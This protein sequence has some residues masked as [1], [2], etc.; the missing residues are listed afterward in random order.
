[1]K[2][3]FV[4]ALAAAMPVVGSAQ[5]AG[6]VIS[7]VITI[8]TAD[9]SVEIV[10]TSGAAID[11]S[12]VILTDEETG[13]GEGAVSFPAS[14][15]IS[16]GEVIVVAVTA[17][18][19][20]PAWLDSLPAGVRVFVE[21][22]RVASIGAWTAANGNTLMA[23]NDVAGPT[24]NIGLSATDGVALF[25]PTLTF[26]GAGIS[27]PTLCIDGVNW[28]PAG[29]YLP[30]D[31]AGTLDTAATEIPYEHGSTNSW[32]RL[33]SSA[34]T[35]S[36]R[37]FYD[38][39]ET[40]GSHT[41]HGDT[42]DGA[43]WFERTIGEGLTSKSYQFNSLFG[44]SQVV[45]VFDADLD[46]AGVDLKFPFL[47]STLRNVPAHAATISG[48]RACINGNFFNLAGGGGAVQ[49]VKVDGALVNDTVGASADEGG[50]VV[51][52]DGD[53]R[54]EVRPG[55]GWNAT[56]TSD[57]NVP[58]VMASNI[59]VAMNGGAYNFPTTNFYVV[60]RHPRTIVGKTADN[61]LLL[62]S[63]DGRS[64]IAAGM[65]MVELTALM[66]SLGCESAINMDGGG[67]TTA[68]D[69]HAPGN[70]VTNVPS[71][72]SL[73]GV[74]NGLAIVAPAPASTPALDAA[75]AQVGVNASPHAPISVTIA[76]GATQNVTISFVNKGTTTWTSSTVFLGTTEARDRTSQLH[77][78]GD[79]VS[80]TRA[81]PLD[82]ASVAP[83]GTGSFT[84]QI[85]APTTSSVL[86]LV[87]SFGLVTSGNVFFGP[88]QNRL[89]VTVVP[90]SLAGEV[91]VESRQSDVAGTLTPSPT[92]VESGSFSNTTSKSS[93]PVPDA[94]G[95]GAR[96]STTVGNSAT[97]RPDI[98][99]AGTYDVFVTIGTGSNNN[100][101]ASFVID[102]TGAD[103]TGSV[104]LSFTD[105]TVVNQ[106]KQIADDVHFAAGT[107]G[108]ITFTNVDGNNATGARFVMDAVRFS[109][110][111]PDP[112]G[113]EGWNQY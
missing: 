61:H 71:D 38:A 31:M 54:L 112:T 94:I 81:T 13:T 19:T 101:N 46:A 74:A 32:Q 92:Y 23:L 52:A 66:M 82:Q 107:G 68:W 55:A 78:P 93:V 88:E 16:P 40:I 64:S 20:E 5:Y 2:T 39:P 37:C 24:A 47:A 29:P 15:T 28:D 84:F 14:T 30:I 1:M 25:E 72:G 77:T 35:G 109:L 9:E 42:I 27:D 102:S 83:G 10:N 100:A 21:P 58:S 53:V 43:Q 36:F 60:D 6:L 70:G 3:F 87:E 33:R 8:P 89:Y 76:T 96:F 44:S 48:A 80:A 49:Y 104:A 108:I 73:R 26:S 86:N 90:A 110:A 113:V 7:E 59:P 103:V 12:G 62:V 106:W 75:R 18:A 22:A 79:W 91:V 11:L 85:T 95:T 69:A 67:S 34:N 41:F 4:A 17:N 57:A 65:T 50:V 111:T 105:P 56:Y 98:P 45:Y 97:F 51:E 99:T 63:V